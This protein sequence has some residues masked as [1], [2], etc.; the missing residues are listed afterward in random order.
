MQ[1]VGDSANEPKQRAVD[2]FGDL[3][4]QRMITQVRPSDLS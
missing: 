2:D 1:S 3:D 4:A